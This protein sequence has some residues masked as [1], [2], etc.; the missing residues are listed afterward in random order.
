MK[1]DGTRITA[2]KFLRELLA[3]NNEKDEDN[4]DGSEDE[5]DV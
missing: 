5:G 3:P 1:A 2:N 4:E